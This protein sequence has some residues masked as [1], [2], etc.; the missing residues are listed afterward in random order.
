MRKQYLAVNGVPLLQYSLRRLASHPLISQVFVVLAPDDAEFEVFRCGEVSPKVRP[1]Y[2]GAD[3][4]AASVHNGLL[5]ARDAF[6]ADDWVLVHDAARPCLSRNA[7]D[8]LIR[9]IGGDEVGGLLAIP[10]ANA[11]TARTA[12]PRPSDAK[13]CGR[14]RR[15]RCSATA[16][17]SMRCVPAAPER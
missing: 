1:L 14:R 17:W 5:A 9:E 4:R 12:S 8:R 13:A 2:C 6:E 10:V 3:R 15:P 16:R 7:L 11:S